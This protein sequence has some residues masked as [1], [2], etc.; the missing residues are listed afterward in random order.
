MLASYQQGSSQTKC[1][2]GVSQ[3]QF[4]WP[5]TNLYAIRQYSQ[6]KLFTLYNILN[7]VHCNI[8]MHEAI[9]TVPAA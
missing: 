2:G 7:K 8:L 6:I 3:L 4:T 1:D 5:N 9:A